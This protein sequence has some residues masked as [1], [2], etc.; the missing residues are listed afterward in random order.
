MKETQLPKELR[1]L[2]S[3]LLASGY[4]HNAKFVKQAA[5]WI[6]KRLPKKKKATR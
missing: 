6:E 3:W 4:E 1:D 2:S 5:N